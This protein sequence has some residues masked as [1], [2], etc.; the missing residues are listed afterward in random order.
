ML[1]V[2]V[3]CVVWWIADDDGVRRSRSLE[4]DRSIDRVAAAGAGAA[5]V[6]RRSACLAVGGVG[7]GWIKW[8][9]INNNNR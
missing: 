2:V 3:L 4:I 7:S 5:V 8:A 1:V 6:D 9:V